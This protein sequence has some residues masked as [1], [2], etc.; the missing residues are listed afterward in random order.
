MIIE[1]IHTHNKESINGII[2]YDPTVDNYEMVQEKWYSVGVHPWNTHIYNE[3]ILEKMYCI[4]I[5]NN[6]IAIGE[7]GIDKL[8]GGTIENQINLFEQHIKLSEQLQKPL[9]IH[10]VKAVDEIIKLHKQYVPTQK[11]IY[12]G[13]RGK[14][15]LAVQLMNQG[16]YL[17][18]G[19]KFNNE[20]LSIASERGMA[21]RETD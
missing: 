8:K 21:F 17:S 19:E 11:W 7:S 6:V 9:I 5:K 14:P 20:S 10:C 12:H 1:D 3:K 13:F 2:N 15:E 18:F 16:I 4:A